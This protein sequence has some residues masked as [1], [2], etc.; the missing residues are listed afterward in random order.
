[1]MDKPKRSHIEIPE[2]LDSVVRTAISEGRTLR[3]RKKIIGILKKTGAVAAALLICV[4]SLLNLSPAFAKAAYRVPVLG[5]LCRIVTFSEYHF[6]DKIK[7]IDAKIPQIE[8]TGKS[9]LEKRVNLEIRKAI[10]ECIAE[11]EEAAKEYYKAFVE[12]GGK[13]ED[14]IPIGI[15]VDYTIKCINEQYVSFVVSQY[16]TA[17]SAYNHELYYNIDLEDG[18]MLTLKDWYGNDYKQIVAGSIENTIANWSAEQ[19]EM[20][21]EDL[22][23]IDLISENTDFYINQENQIVVVFSRYE[24]AYGAAGALEFTIQTAG[25]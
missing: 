15:T 13:P 20:L 17:F 16:E 24:A 1:M 14:F 11:N 10:N 22:S 5:E 2:E 12:T 8:N 18:K 7:Y 25:D 4:I 19:K 21:W 3:R 9:D 6:E 23:V